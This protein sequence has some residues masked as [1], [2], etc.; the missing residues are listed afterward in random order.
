MSL[1]DPSVNA[2]LGAAQVNIASMQV[3]RR[4][5]GGAALMVLTVDSAIPPGTLADIVERIGAASGRAV[6]LVEG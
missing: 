3:S 2:V 6:D 5:Q 1:S 4:S